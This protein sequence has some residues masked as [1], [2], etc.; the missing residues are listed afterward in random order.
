M[1]KG[2][3]KI[4]LHRPKRCLDDMSIFW[5]KGHLTPKINIIFLYHKFD[6]EYFHVE[7]FFWKISIFRGK[8]KKLF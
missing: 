4:R 6:T 3:S 7:Q 8:C 2:G 5:E 1:H